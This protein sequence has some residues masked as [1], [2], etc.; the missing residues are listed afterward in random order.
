MLRLHGADAVGM[1]TIHE[2]ALANARGVPTSAYSLITN[3]LTDT[4][5]NMLD[6]DDVTETSRRQLP[7]I[8]GIIDG[9][10][11]MIEGKK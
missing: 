3:M 11:E 4:A 7:V 2:V 8:R 10:R 5:M 9:H 6:H 1:S